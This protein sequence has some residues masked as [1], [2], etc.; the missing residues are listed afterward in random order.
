[1]NSKPDPDVFAQLREGIAVL[2]GGYREVE[3]VPVA[4][5]GGRASDSGP[6]ATMP[7]YDDRVWAALMAA[8]RILGADPNYLATMGTVV[9]MRVQDL[10]RDQLRTFIT[11]MLRGERFV[12]GYTARYIADGRLLE[13]LDRVMLLGKGLE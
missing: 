10:D 13:A 6:V 7:D 3:W 1:M 9:E 12:T 4:G 11:V 2:R 8:S 5:S